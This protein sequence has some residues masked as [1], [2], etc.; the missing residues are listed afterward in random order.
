M[1]LGRPSFIHATNTTASMLA[2]TDFEGL[3][4][5]NRPE[6]VTGVNCFIAMAELS[7]ILNEILDAFFTIGSVV[8]LR[9]VAGD[10]IVQLHDK[11]EHDLGMWRQAHL[12]Q[13]L[14]QRFFPD[15]SGTVRP[16]HQIMK[17]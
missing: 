9:E 11:I 4:N 7:I 8:K 3:D 10:H 2:A 15:V 12:K 17:Y 1:A 13:I 14:A 6:L 16:R 5:A